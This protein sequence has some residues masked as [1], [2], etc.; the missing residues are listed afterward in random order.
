MLEDCARVGL[1]LAIAMA[2][3]CTSPSVELPR[4]PNG[5]WAPATDSATDEPSDAGPSTANASDASAAPSAG[6]GGTGGAIGP[7]VPLPGC[8]GCRLHAPTGYAATK[9]APL[10]IAL[11]GDEGPAAG[12]PS[13]ISLWSTAADKHGAFVLA[14]PC[15]AELACSDGNWS[16]WLAGQG[17]QITPANMAWMNAQAAKVESLYNI[18]VKREYASGYSGGAYVM[19]YFGQAQAARYAAVA[20]IA[21]GMP[22]WTGTG[23]ACPARKIP[24]YFLGGDGDPR[25]GGQMS[26]TAQSFSSCGQPVELDVVKGADHE[27]AIGSLGAGRADVILGWFETHALP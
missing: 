2:M 10:L 1:V 7:S 3:G 22:A 17:Y 21:G 5:E 6:S 13:V 23:H 8:A 15:G 27:G 9:A 19:G 18:D 26:D 14:L 20:F 11:H 24:G 4:R 25:T 16:G 12:V